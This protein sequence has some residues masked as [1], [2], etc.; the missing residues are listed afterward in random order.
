MRSEIDIICPEYFYLRWQFVFTARPNRITFANGENFYY[1]CIVSD[2]MTKM[3]EDKMY[4]VWIN[5]DHLLTLKIVPMCLRAAW[6]RIFSL[7]VQIIRYENVAMTIHCLFTAN[8]Y[9][10]CNW[11]CVRDMKRIQKIICTK[12]VVFSCICLFCGLLYQSS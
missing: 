1:Y 5:S 11:I 4:S 2:K 9:G 10:K 8:H 6:N 7:D 3:N 12:C